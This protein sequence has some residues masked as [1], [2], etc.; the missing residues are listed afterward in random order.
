MLNDKAKIVSIKY[1]EKLENLK[2]P[3][4]YNNFLKSV[5]SLL[6]IKKNQVKNIK[7]SYLNHSSQKTYIIHNND[8]YI[9]FLNNYYKGYNKM[10]NIE[11]FK[12]YENI[13]KNIGIFFIINC[14]FCKLKKKSDIVYYCKDCDI[15]FCK[16][17]E[18]NKGKIHKHC[19]YKINNNINKYIIK[20]IYLIKDFFFEGIKMIGNLGTTI[21]N[22]FVND[23]KNIDDDD[24]INIPYKMYYIGDKNKKIDISNEKQ[25]KKLVEDT[26]N[27]YKLYKFSYMEIEKALIE[28]NGNINNAVSM[29]INNF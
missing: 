7:I 28:N 21:K 3:L 12:E 27:Y 24:N 15:Y 11:L 8:S 17:C 1:F 26:K 18:I 20:F 25:L 9:A 10:I 23:N 29:L 22:Y 2:L 6:N 16:E 4:D 14:A 19:Y 5:I 13:P